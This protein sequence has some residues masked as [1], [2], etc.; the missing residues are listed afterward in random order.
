VVVKNDGAPM[1]ANVGNGDPLGVHLEERIMV[2]GAWLGGAGKDPLKDLDGE[3][4]DGVWC[5]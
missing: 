5:A 2:G 3:V 4:V 1:A